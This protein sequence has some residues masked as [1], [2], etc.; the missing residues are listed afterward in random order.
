VPAG[1]RAEPFVVEALGWAFGLVHRIPAAQA[2]AAVGSATPISDT[3]TIETSTPEGRLT[4]HC[5]REVPPSL[6]LMAATMA[7]ML[8]LM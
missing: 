8:V 3:A 1:S 2:V 7:Y 6:A 5:G 4:S